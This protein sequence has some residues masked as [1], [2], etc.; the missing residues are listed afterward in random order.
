MDSYNINKYI[1]KSIIKNVS[2]QKKRVPPF[3]TQN[4]LERLF[5]G[6]LKPRRKSDFRLFYTHAP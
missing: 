5:S 2:L 1:N 6:K 4:S 3:G